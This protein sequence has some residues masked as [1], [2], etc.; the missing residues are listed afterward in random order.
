MD[1][2]RQVILRT[3]PLGNK[4]TNTDTGESTGVFEDRT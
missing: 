1:T 3:H 2:E 4:H